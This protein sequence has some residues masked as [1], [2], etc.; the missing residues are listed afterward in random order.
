MSSSLNLDYKKKKEKI[1][2][3]EIPYNF[4]DLQNLIRK[5]YLFDSKTIIT[6]EYIDEENEPTELSE[7]IYS[8]EFMIEIM[9]SKNPEIKIIEES[10]DKEKSKKNNKVEL[11]N[12]D[13]DLD[14]IPTSQTIENYSAPMT[15]TKEVE[16]IIYY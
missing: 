14:S 10:N 8:K 12:S 11:D 16:L 6:L 13:I 5:K 2:E 4:E 9:N 15:C 7:D 3:N 1:K